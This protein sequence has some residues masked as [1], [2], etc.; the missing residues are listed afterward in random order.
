MPEFAV[1]ART[2]LAKRELHL[3]FLSA[4]LVVFHIFNDAAS[5]E[6]R[7]A[8]ARALLGVLDLWEPGDILIDAVTYLNLPLINFFPVHH[9]N[10]L[11]NK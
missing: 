3:Q 7:S 4:E 6:S 1:M 2:A 11:L 10:R 9:T 8:M 5:L